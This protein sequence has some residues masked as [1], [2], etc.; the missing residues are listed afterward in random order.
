[1]TKMQLLQQIIATLTADLAVLARAAR[2]AHE[3]ATHEECLPDNKYD[4]TALEASYV[5]QGQANRAQ[6]IR[7]ALE[8]YRALALQDFS[9]DAPIRLTALVVLEDEIGCRRQV[10]L[11]PAAGGVKVVAGGCETIVITPQSP[12][13]RSLLGRVAGDELTSGTGEAAKTYTIVTI[14]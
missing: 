1:M 10:F 4:T 8:S 7:A 11:G 6:E 2:T 5:A 12:L 3:A 13:G 9:E 14:R